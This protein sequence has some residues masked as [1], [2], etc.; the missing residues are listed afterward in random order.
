LLVAGLA[1]VLASAAG[2]TAIPDLP[3]SE[4]ASL[5]ENPEL[6]LSRRYVVLS[7]ADSESVFLAE[8]QEL[9][10]SRR[11]AAPFAA[12]SESALLA[13]NPELRLSRR[14]VSPQTV[15]HQAVDLCCSWESRPK[16]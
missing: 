6:L 14:F 13:E 2:R 7:A 5:A 4:T 12:D 15:R 10:L 16:V 1:W 11:H 9:L 8:N 3:T